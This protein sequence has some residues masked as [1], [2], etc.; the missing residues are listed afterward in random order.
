MSDSA[1]KFISQITFGGIKREIE[2]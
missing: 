2:S 1:T